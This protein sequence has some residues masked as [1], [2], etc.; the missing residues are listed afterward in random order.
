MKK[1]FA[2]RGGLKKKLSAISA[3]TKTPAGQSKLKNAVKAAR[4]KK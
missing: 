2:P 4:K 1:A 3:T